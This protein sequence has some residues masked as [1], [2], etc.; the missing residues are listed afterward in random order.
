MVADITENE[1][2]AEELRGSILPTSRLQ[3]SFGA[4]VIVTMFTFWAVAYYGSKF[5]LS[6]DELWVRAARAVSSPR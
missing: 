5:Y 1:R 3:M 2:K 6:S 4:H